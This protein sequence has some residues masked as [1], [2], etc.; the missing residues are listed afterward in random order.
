MRTPLTPLP[1]D[2]TRW[3]R[4]LGW[5]RA[6]DALL[7]WFGAWAALAL[8][9]PHARAVSLAVLAAAVVGACAASRPVRLRW[10]PVSGAV[11]VYVSR[12]L[13]AGDRAWFVRAADAELVLVTARHGLRL[14]VAFGARGPAEGISVRRTRVLLVPTAEAPGGGRA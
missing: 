5:M 10:R 2:I 6:L 12:S 3:M 4:L 8:A 1:D 13:S 11:G 7:A 14:V 9:A